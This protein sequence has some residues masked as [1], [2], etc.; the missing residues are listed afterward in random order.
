MV[1]Y[2]GVPEG[3]VLG[4]V[5]F[6]IYIYDIDIGLSNFIAKFASNTKIV[7]LVISDRDKRSIQE[8]LRKISAW[9]DRWE[10]PFNVNKY[11]IFQMGTINKKYEY[12]VSGVK[13][14]SVQCVKDLDV[15]IASNLKFSLNCKEAVC[16]ANRMLSFMKRNFSFKNRDIIL[17]M[18]V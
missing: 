5:L 2:S 18:Y 11:H 7:N 9:S 12:E 3:S 13:L 17:P 8:D 1:D 10:M 16:K 4:P 15:T 14:E 6:I